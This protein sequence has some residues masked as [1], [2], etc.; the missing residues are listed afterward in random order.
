MEEVFSG[1]NNLVLTHVIE[2][3]IVE[4]QESLDLAIVARAIT[5]C[6]MVCKLVAACSGRVFR[7][8]MEIVSTVKAG[9]NA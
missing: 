1:M 7:R 5:D 9:A 3:I 4:E 6:V 2:D 8:D